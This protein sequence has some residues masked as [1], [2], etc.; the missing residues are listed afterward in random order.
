M[1]KGTIDNA[2]KLAAY[3]PWA[4]GTISYTFFQSLPGYYAGQKIGWPGPTRFFDKTNTRLDQFDSVGVFQSLTSTEQ[5]YV[6]DFLKKQSNAFA[7]IQFGAPSTSN[8][9]MLSY[10]GLQIDAVDKNGFGAGAYAS[11]GNANGQAADGNVWLFN[12][13]RQADKGNIQGEPTGSNYQDYFA[14]V[15]P[16]ETGH[17]LGLQHS[18]AISSYSSAEDSFKYSLM[19][20][21]LHSAELRGAYEYQLYDIASL[22]YLYGRKD[23]TANSTYKDF[24]ASFSAASAYTV[25][26]AVTAASFDRI[27]SIYD[28]GGTDTINA[29]AYVGKSAYVDLRPG[30]FSSIGPE[31]TDNKT[32]EY[33]NGNWR[34]NYTKDIN[35][36]ESLGRE[37]ISIAFGAYIENATGGSANDNSCR[38]NPRYLAA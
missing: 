15:I 29:S 1:T 23:V 20:Y 35:G 21:N 28:G 22:Q 12:G 32:I 8:N 38:R 26:G 4:P 5:A 3:T 11:L 30:H 9:A 6:T 17:A 27:F 14:W 7:N 24:H 33:T 2:V 34:V 16:H 10:G 19:S 31:A 36:I 13:A 25:G 37:N 18:S